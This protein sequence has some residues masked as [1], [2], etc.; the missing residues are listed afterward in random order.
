MESRDQG[1]AVESWKKKESRDQRRESR[2]EEDGVERPAS[3]GRGQKKMES[4]DQRRESRAEEDG[5]ERPASRGEGRRRWSRETSVESRGQ[6]K[7]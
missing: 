3:S 1:R 6:K 4:R 5:V 7:K 2:A